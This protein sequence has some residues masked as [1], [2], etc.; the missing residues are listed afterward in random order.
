LIL[1]DTSAGV[2]RNYVLGNMAMAFCI[3]TNQSLN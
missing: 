3:F 2:S 1:W